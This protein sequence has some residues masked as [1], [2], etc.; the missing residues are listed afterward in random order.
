MTGSLPRRSVNVRWR[1]SRASMSGLSTS[2]LSPRCAASVLSSYPA[3]YRAWIASWV[4]QRDGD[5]PGGWLHQLMPDAVSPSP[6]GGGKAPHRMRGAPHTA[7]VPK[8]GPTPVARGGVA[9]VVARCCGRLRRPDRNAAALVARCCGRLRRPDR[10]ARRAASKTFPYQA[11]HIAALRLR[12]ASTCIGT[13]RAR[14]GGRM[15]PSRGRLAAASARP[16]QLP[17]R[18][19][20]Q[21]DGR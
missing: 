1:W 18:H 9:F 13:P 5:A 3:H 7:A 6:Q 21:G 4:V 12:R 20:G 14:R 2:N 11:R 16:L 8:R 15:S 10:N 19:D 17:H